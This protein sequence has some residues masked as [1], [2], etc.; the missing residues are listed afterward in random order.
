MEPVQILQGQVLVEKGQLVDREVY[1]NLE[2]AGVLNTEKSVLPFV[3]L[4]LLIAFIFMGLLYFYRIYERKNEKN[5][6]NLL[7]FGLVYAIS[8]LLLK[9]ISTLSAM[10]GS[11]FSFFIPAA[12]GTMLL[13]VL[14]DDRYAISF[15]IIL[16]IFGAII[17]NENATSNFNIT[18]GLY[19]LLSGT[20]AILLLSVRQ[21]KTR[22]FQTGLLLSLC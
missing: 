13:K 7:I 12:L 15:T 19:I 16:G 20:S 5:P 10:E 8:I 17:F 11:D 4:G 21:L 9:G 18:V 6:S 22:L 2:L 14:L 1:R 3:G